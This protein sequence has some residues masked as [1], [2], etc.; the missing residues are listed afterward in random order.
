MAGS[1]AVVLGTLSAIGLGVAA[2]LGTAAVATTPVVFLAAGLLTVIVLTF[3]VGWA[4]FRV[5]RVRCPMPA[6]GGLAVATGLVVC[7][8]ASATILR[9][10]PPQ[11]ATPIPSDVRFWNLPSGSRI[12]YVHAP[13]ANPA[14]SRDTPVIFLHGGPGTPGEG[15]PSGGEEL[16]DAGFD[17]YAYDQV[18]AGR[19][20]RLTDVRG[21]TVERQVEDLEAIRQTLGAQRLILVG[22]SWGGSLAAQYLA[23]HPDRVA[24]A[25]F[26]APG[27]IWGGAYTEDGVGEPWTEMNAEQQARYDELTSAPR[28]LAQALLMSVDPNAARALV[29]DA[30]ADSW[31]HEIALTGRD[32]TSCSG[33][34][35]TPPHDNPQGFYVNQ[36]TNA[37]FAR[38]PD[39]RPALRQVRV[40]AL[41]M[42]A[43]CDFIRWPVTREYRDVLPGS[44]LVDIRGAG[45]ALSTDQPAVYVDLLRSFLLDQDLTLPAYTAQDPPPDRWAR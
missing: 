7:V 16:A 5:M 27:A 19:S 28:V 1:V 8:V 44:T 23:S 3:V 18:G 14:E 13:A 22:R 43:Q 17:V 21:Y 36:L 40:P 10:F 2:A 6:A 32:G 39:P 12:A 25:V 33:A 31:M 35:S 29:P 20:T 38:I 42:A 9:P 34:P 37:D 30:E 4:G 15:I 41:V 45:H 26:V 11:A 24:K